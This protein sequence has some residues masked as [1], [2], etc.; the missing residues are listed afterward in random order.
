MVKTQAQA[1]IKPSRA[2]RTDGDGGAHDGGLV[3]KI[4]IR[5]I[6]GKNPYELWKDKKANISYFHSFGYVKINLSESEDKDSEG[7]TKNIEAKDSEETQ[8]E[9]VICP[10]HQKKSRSR[11]SHS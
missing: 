10:T 5:P 8:P 3:N 6:Q 2:G 4:S 7:K 11:T 9:A 1:R